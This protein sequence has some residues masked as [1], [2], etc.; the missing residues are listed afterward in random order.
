[1]AEEYAEPDLGG[2]RAAGSTERPLPEWLVDATV[3]KVRKRNRIGGVTTRGVFGTLL[4]LA[5]ALRWSAVSWCVQT[6]FVEREHGTDRG[7]NARKVRKTYRFSKDGGV[8]TALTY[9]TMYSYNFC[10]WV[11]SL[12]QPMAAKRYRARRACRKSCVR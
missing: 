2:P 3:Q 1:L 10:W 11:G 4:S 9:F 12:R 8:P 6:G 7:R 5:A